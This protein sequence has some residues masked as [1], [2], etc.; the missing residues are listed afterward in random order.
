[1]ACHMKTT[2]EISDPLF[3]EARTVAARRR[4]T[5]RQ[6]VEAGLRKVIEED[7]QPRK[8]FRLRDGSVG[9]KGLCEG[10]SYDDWGAILDLGYGE[11]R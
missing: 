10:L 1:M 3:R 4:Q 6:L 9:G 11:R 8:H 2:I 7:K 5:L